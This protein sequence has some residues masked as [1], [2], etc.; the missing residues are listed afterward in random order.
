MLYNMN[1]TT[2]EE[3]YYILPFNRIMLQENDVVIDIFISDNEMTVSHVKVIRYRYYQCQS[4]ISCVIQTF[5]QMQLP[6][7]ALYFFSHLVSY[8]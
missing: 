6:P 7:T 8:R 3:N 2:A 1:Y 5:P 4:V